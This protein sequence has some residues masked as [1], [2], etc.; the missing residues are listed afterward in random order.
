MSLSDFTHAKQSRDQKLVSCCNSNQGASCWKVSAEYLE[1]YI[2]GK[3]LDVV[4]LCTGAAKVC[5]FAFAT[6]R[7]S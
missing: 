3:E 5:K 6:A 7:E 4:V 1:G 2:C